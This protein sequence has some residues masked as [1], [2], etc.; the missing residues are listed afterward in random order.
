MIN[1]ILKVNIWI[2][3]GILFLFALALRLYH[4]GSLPITFQEDEILSGYVGRYILQNG[5]DIYG[6]A[7]PLL[8]FNKF[9]DF[10]I[11]LPMYLIGFA[12]YIFGINEF[13]VR[14]PAALMG[15]L[16]VFPVYWLAAKTFRKRAVGYIAAFL[17]AITPWHWVLSRAIVEGIIGSTIFLSGIVFLLKGSEKKSIRDIIFASF[18]FFIT[19]FIYHPFRMYVPLIFFP[20]YFLFQLQKS[21]KVFSTV[22]VVH[23]FF[24]LLTMY[25]GTT[26]WGSGR[27][28]QTS[29]FSELSGVQITTQQQIFNLGDGHLIEAKIFHNKL[30]GFG[31]EF[32]KQ[33]LTYFSPIFLFIQG[34]AESRYDVPNQGLYFLSYLAYLVAL[35]L[36]MTKKKLVPDAPLLTYLV[37]LI[38]LA[39]LPAAITYLGSPNIHRAALLGVVLIIPVSFGLYK[40]CVSKYK[41]ILIPLVFVF[42]FCEVS[43][44]WHQYTTQ[45]D[46]YTSM[47]RNDGFKELVQYVVQHKNEYDEVLLPAEGNTALYYLF[48]T[49]DFSPTYAKKFTKDAHIDAV[50]N[51]RFILSS[52]PSEKV[53]AEDLGKKILVVNRHNCPDTPTFK[54]IKRIQGVNI[55]LGFHVLR[56]NLPLIGN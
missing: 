26:P 49:K 46:I 21:K 29:I 18:L 25:I 55:L 30:I 50:S 54:E 16:V 45:A 8:Y 44:F 10:Y 12:T 15:S 17:I 19:Y 41:L 48:F 13:A 40:I 33:Y 9:G 34:G 5:T 22:L 7:W 39:P 32:V 11:I 37:Y 47:R 1:K 3:L 35:A 36:P 14:F 24:I 2:I 53:T 51:I 31:R 4:L 6:N 20:A 56:P 42:L 27:F 38:L 23:I 52:C 43:Y 28:M